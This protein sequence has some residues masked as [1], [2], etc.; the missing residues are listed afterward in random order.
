MCEVAAAYVTLLRGRYATSKAWVQSMGAH[1]H[2][3][4]AMDVVCRLKLG[5]VG[6]SENQS[7]DALVGAFAVLLCVTLGG[8]ERWQAC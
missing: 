4:A 7:R 3:V 2:S 8:S 6:H 5:G 1:N